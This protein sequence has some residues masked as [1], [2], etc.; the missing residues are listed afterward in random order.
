MKKIEDRRWYVA[1]K[2]HITPLFVVAAIVVSAIKSRNIE[3][4]VLYLIA[5]FCGVY[6]VRYFGERK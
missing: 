4:F 5:I 6:T 1:D 2:W 3:T